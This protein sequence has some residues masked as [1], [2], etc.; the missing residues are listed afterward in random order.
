MQGMQTRSRNRHDRHHPWI[1]ALR[2]SRHRGRE[3]HRQIAAPAGFVGV[4]LLPVVAYL[5]QEVG[6]ANEKA[7]AEAA[8]TFTE[9]RYDDTVV[10]AEQGLR[11][12]TQ[13]NDRDN[14]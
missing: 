3:K 8:V 4:L 14:A 13:L 11:D 10:R 7:R 9:G 6:D 1:P 12:L 2:S 5:G